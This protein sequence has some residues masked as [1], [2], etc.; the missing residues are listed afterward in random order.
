MSSQPYARITNVYV[1]TINPMIF[2]YALKRRVNMGQTE[3]LAPVFKNI[4]MLS[5]IGFLARGMS[6]DLQISEYSYV[7]SSINIHVDP[8]T[9]SRKS[10]SYLYAKSCEML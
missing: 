2:S 6:E 1:C 10:L 3:F 4:E 8:K 7:G 9:V 5:G